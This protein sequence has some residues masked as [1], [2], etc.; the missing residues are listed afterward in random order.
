MSNIDMIRFKNVC[1]EFLEASGHKVTSAKIIEN[2][3]HLQYKEA[4]QGIFV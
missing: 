4:S 3:I 1:I 2:E